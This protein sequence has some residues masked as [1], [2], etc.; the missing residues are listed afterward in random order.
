MRSKA[1]RRKRAE[2]AL[3]LVG[4]DERMHHLPSELSGGQQQRVAVARAIATNPAM[5]LADEPT[6]NLDTKSTGEV[7]EIFGRL[8]ADGRTVVMITHED[9]VAR[10]AKRVIRLVDG[11]IIDD[12]RQ[13][14]GRRPAAAVPRADIRRARR[15]GRRAVDGMNLENFRIA[16]QG[17]LAN[18][19]RS[20]LTMLGMMIGVGAV[21]LVV[22]VGN[23]SSKAVAAR[24]SS[25]GTNTLTMLQ[26][27]RLRR[28]GG[29]KTGTQSQRVILNQKDV[30][31][32][33]EQE[34]RARRHRRVAGRQR[35]GRHR[36]LQRQHVLAVEFHRR[37]PR[38]RVDQELAHDRRHASSP[39]PMSTTTP[40]SWCW[41]P[42]R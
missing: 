34:Q 12:H 19:L 40:R 18:R 10:H 13:G 11:Q 4:L 29:R 33:S 26:H 8:N 27:G 20:A 6:G 24:L 39:R 23:G 17:I 30:T 25:L 3:R 14:P 16:L 32:L 9:D 7:L 5:I 37:L 36:L 22:A 15:P 2:R 42:R 38:L 1:E 28:R 41:G 21:I 35:L 31:A